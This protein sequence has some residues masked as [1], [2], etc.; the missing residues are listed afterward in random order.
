MNGM[1]KVKQIENIIFEVRGKKVILDRDISI[2]YNIETRIL[3]QKVK[4]NINKFS[5]DSFFN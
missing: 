4:R 3:N 5:K 2:L 1:K